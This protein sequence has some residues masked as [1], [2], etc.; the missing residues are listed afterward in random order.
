VDDIDVTSNMSALPTPDPVV[1]R[2]LLT[3]AEA[4]DIM[5]IGRT[6]AYELVHRFVESGGAE[7]I[8]VVRIGRCWRVPHAELLERI[9]RGL[10]D[11]SGLARDEL[12]PR[13]LDTDG[14]GAPTG[15]GRPLS[16]RHGGQVAGT[17]RPRREPP[18][19]QL[20]LFPAV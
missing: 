19:D 20:P 15:G 17:R 18:P 12:A 1:Q 2:Y 13:L 14:A 8:P 3:V 16:I 10:I 4:A 9:R 11:P 5:G 7:G 6:Y